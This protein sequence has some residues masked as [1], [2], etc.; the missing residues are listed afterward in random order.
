MNSHAIVGTVL[1]DIIQRLYC[2]SQG[3]KLG[4]AVVG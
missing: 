1:W 2:P 4:R 3:E